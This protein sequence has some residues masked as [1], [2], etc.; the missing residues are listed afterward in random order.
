MVG[1]TLDGPSAHL[2]IQF[3]EWLSDRPRTYGETMDAW[4]TS[5]PRLSIW[6]DALSGGVVRLGQGTLRERQVII[7]QRGRSLLLSLSL[8]RTAEEQ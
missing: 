4:R 3:L 8:S 5:C 7:T 1:P 6:E 2:T